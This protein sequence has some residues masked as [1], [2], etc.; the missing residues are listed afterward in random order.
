MSY[1]VLIKWTTDR[2]CT[3]DDIHEEAVKART[4]QSFHSRWADRR[5]K[6]TTE[7]VKLVLQG[8]ASGRCDSLGRLKVILS[9][10]SPAMIRNY[11][12]VVRPALGKE[13]D[14]AASHHEERSKSKSSSDPSNN[15]G[16]LGDN[17]SNARFPSSFVDVPG[18]AAPADK[19]D[20]LTRQ[21][22][23]L[24]TPS[25]EEKAAQDNNAQEKAI[26]ELPILVGEYKRVKDDKDRG[27]GTNQLRMNLTSSIK[28]LEAIGIT[29]VPVYG[30]Q[31][32]GPIA[33]VSAAVMKNGVC[34]LTVYV[35]VGVV[36][37]HIADRVYS[38][39]CPP[40]RAADDQDRHIDANGCLAL[41]YGTLP[42]RH[43]ARCKTR[44]GVS[45][46]QS[47]IDRE[48]DN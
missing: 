45:Q 38:I 22:Q 48:C 27:T 14:S 43:Y 3:D 2:G 47:Q 5:A 36:Q 40:L 10:I 42:A 6:R 1:N 9:D 25:S 30:V 19:V 7:E 29:G 24:P 37:K 23:N 41:C 35:V 18:K 26:L 4:L 46:S 8:P 33:A 16:D 21:M 13:D 31:T 34:I 39:A 17:I 28:F 32:E 12:L 11:S 44:K 15:E 20:E